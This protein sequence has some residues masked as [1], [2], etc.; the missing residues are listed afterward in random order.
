MILCDVT[1]RDLFDLYGISLSLYTVAQDGAA[2]A[3]AAAAAAGR[4]AC[5]F[6]EHTPGL[7]PE[8]PTLRDQTYPGSSGDYW[9]EIYL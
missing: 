3:P 1:R 2:A 5:A 6:E 9:D 4:G 8:K 7:R